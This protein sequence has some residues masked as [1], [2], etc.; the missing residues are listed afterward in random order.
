MASGDRDLMAVL[1]EPCTRGFMLQIDIN[2]A[3]L[4]RDDA[5][6]CT[7]PALPPSANDCLLGAGVLKAP[8]SQRRL[9]AF[10]IG[11]GVLAWEHSDALA[12]ETASMIERPHG[13]VPGGYELSPVAKFGAPLLRRRYCEPGSQPACRLQLAQ[14]SEP[15]CGPRLLPTT[16]S[17]HPHRG[18]ARSSEMTAPTMV[19][20]EDGKRKRSSC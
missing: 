3:E 5:D 11:G 1:V 8:D 9:M 18:H 13:A 2:G 10:R 6:K 15:K 19:G 16:A 14:V 17:K 4:L 20:A 12:A 7:G